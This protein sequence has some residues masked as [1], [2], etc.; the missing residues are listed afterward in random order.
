LTSI[1]CEAYRVNTPEISD[2]TVLTGLAEGGSIAGSK[3]L[4]A[5]TCD[6]FQ[7]A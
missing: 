2:S 7:D 5:I 1:A 6:E 3:E 4:A